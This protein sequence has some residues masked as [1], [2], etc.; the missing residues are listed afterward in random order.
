MTLMTAV[1]RLFSMLHALYWRHRSLCAQANSK[2][3]KEAM[4]FCSPSR[5]IAST[6]YD[7]MCR[8]SSAAFKKKMRKETKSERERE[9]DNNEAEVQILGARCFYKMECTLAL[10]HRSIIYCH[11]RWRRAGSE[12]QWIPITATAITTDDSSENT[13]HENRSSG[14]L[15]CELW[16]SEE[17][18][19]CGN[20][21]V[22]QWE[23][24]RKL[25]W[26]M[27][28]KTVRGQIPYELLSCAGIHHPS[29]LHVIR[30]L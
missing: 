26:K 27:S 24:C 8:H 19:T 14:R 29:T 21:G 1:M 28:E 13:A 9:R 17:V 6:S 20:E 11:R 23:N 16:E 4:C 12:Q 10:V 15:V 30:Y 18:G 5:S 2:W 3:R 7:A 25:H 22:P